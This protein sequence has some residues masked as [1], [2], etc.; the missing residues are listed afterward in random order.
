[1]IGLILFL[2]FS[3]APFATCIIS[4]ILFFIIYLV[5]RKS[6]ESFPFWNNIKIVLKKKISII[7]FL[8]ATIIL[9]LFCIAPNIL[10]EYDS[11]FIQ[12]GTVNIELIN[13]Y[14][15]EYTIAAQKQISDYQKAQ[16]DAAKYATATQL[17]FWSQQTDAVGNALT[18]KIKEFKDKILEQEMKQNEAK[19]KFQL[20]PQSKWFFGIV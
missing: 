3:L 6:G 15:D 13:K 2:F 4:T 1:M 7:S 14:I 8:V 9:I 18:N 11:Y 5:V 12:L 17:Q 20:R 19:V 10:Q 16:S